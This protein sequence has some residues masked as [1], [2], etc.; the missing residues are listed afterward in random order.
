MNSIGSF[1]SINDEVVA[2]ISII[3]SSTTDT[4]D[5]KSEIK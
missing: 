1:N 2:N 5:A 4:I 3:S